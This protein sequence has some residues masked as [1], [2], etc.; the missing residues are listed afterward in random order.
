MNSADPGA[1]STAKDATGA[2]EKQEG[3]KKTA[4]DFHR[5]TPIERKSR[6]SS[7]KNQRSSA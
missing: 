5:S 4:A 3:F 6:M 1:G 7:F 2:K